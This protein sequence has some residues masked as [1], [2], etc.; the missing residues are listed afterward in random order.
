MPQPPSLNQALNAVMTSGLP[1][2]Y[3]LVLV[4]LL[5][6]QSRQKDDPYWGL[7]WPSADK[8]AGDT[9]S[10]TSEQAAAALQHMAHAGILRSH[11]TTSGGVVRWE[12]RVEHLASI[13]PLLQTMLSTRLRTVKGLGATAR[14]VLHQLSMLADTSLQVSSS[15]ND[16][17]ASLP[18]LTAGAW[19]WSIRQLTTADVLREVRRGNRFQGTTWQIQVPRSD[20]Q[21]LPSSD[22]SNTQ[23]PA[24]R[25]LPPSN[26]SPNTQLQPSSDESNTQLPAGR[27]LPPSNGSPNTQLQP[28]S[29][30][31]N[32]QLPAGRALPPSNG[33]PNTQLQP[34]SDESNTQ[35]PAGRALPPSNGSP[36]TQLQPS[37][38]ESNTQLPAGRALPPSNGSPNTQL[39]PSSD[40]SNTQLPAGRALPPSN[41]SPNTQL[42][43]SSDESNTQLQPSS[44][45]LNTQL[46]PSSGTLNTQLQPS[47]GT[48]NTQLQPSSGTLNTQLQA[49]RPYIRNILSLNRLISEHALLTTTPS[50]A[51]TVQLPA[52]ASNEQESQQERFIESIEK[53]VDPIRMPDLDT[54]R[55]LAEA[56]EQKTGRTI[57]PAWGE[58]LWK[59]ATQPGVNEPIGF[60]TDR[61][62]RLVRAGIDLSSPP[63]PAPPRR[64]NR[65]DRPDKSRSRYYAGRQEEPDDTHPPSAPKPVTL[66]VPSKTRRLWSG[67]LGDLQGQM[68][69]PSFDTWLKGTEGIS[70]TDDTLVVGAPNTF[71]AEMLERRMHAL[72][73]EAVGRCLRRDVEVRFEVVPEHVRVVNEDGE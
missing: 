50:D 41:G 26:G 64:E 31:S 51:E 52:G 10:V 17:K 5:R 72:I 69:R 1:D 49:A 45:T 56:W 2:H 67:V 30:E 20:T 71:V 36:N 73:L 38:D 24:G 14:H 65:E 39:Q 42:Q 37:S 55:C 33:S 47:S 4:S 27:A 9:S 32:T 3:R 48:L 12:F 19:R 13:D 34:S 7:A 68:T 70:L 25:A 61:F 21:L 59:S 66:R 63:E 8:I 15:F 18:W 44:G 6:H 54:I 23:L 29:D 35:L 53:R 46:Q 16:I 43:P 11:G 40:E 22:E 62:K 58:A 28:S 60:M 57:H